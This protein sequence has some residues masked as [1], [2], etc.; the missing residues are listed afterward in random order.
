VLD[1]T[2]KIS[3]TIADLAGEDAVTERAL[4]EALRYRCASGWGGER[5]PTHPAA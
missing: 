4:A 1:R 5:P 2:L 3:R